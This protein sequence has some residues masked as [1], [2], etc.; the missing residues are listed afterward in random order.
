MRKM[1]A[2]TLND[3]RLFFQ[4]PMN[5]VFLTIMPIIFIYVMGLAF[6]GAG[7]ANVRF[8]LDV[9]DHDASP[10]SQ[11]LIAALESANP[12]VIVCPRPAGITEK[13]AD[14][15]ALGDALGQPLT[16]ELARQRIED[17][18]TYGSLT[19]P[20]GYGAALASGEQIALVFQSN[21][22]LTAPQIVL[23]TVQSVLTRVGGSTIAA[24]LSTET[25]EEWGVV[26]ADNRAAYYAARYAEAQA[27]WGPPPPIQINAEATTGGS[28]RSSAGGF[29]QSTAG[30]AC[31]F[32]MQ[33]VLGMAAILVEERQNRT[34]QR[35]LVMPVSRAQILG[36]KL[37]RGFGIGLFQFS[38]LLVFGHFLGVT[39]GNNLPAALLVM[40]AYV[41]AVTAI[42]MA[43]ATLAHTAPQADGIAL[44]AAMTLAPLGGAWWPLS[45]VPEFMRVIGHISP[46]AWA[47]DAFTS[48]IYEG[49]GLP[50]VIVPVLV[51]LGFAA[52]F[53]TFGVTRFRYE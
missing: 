4:S 7:S 29:G 41:L 21:A 43:L 5:L 37:L 24:R 28:T 16:A 30:M 11:T 23:Q 18:I 6:G 1:I 49:G 3:L 13:E 20:A 48:L 47:M 9:L 50:E 15:C 17:N 45:I 33:T 2:I 46:I 12:N 52:V 26:N 19:I 39:F 27:A 22:D 31:M 34:L 38:V 51:L 32:V 42:S 10:A 44:L 40:L 36:G 8:R 53:F 14:P 35:L 25:A